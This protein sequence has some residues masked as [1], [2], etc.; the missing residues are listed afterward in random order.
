MRVDQ[1]N[2]QILFVT[3]E[4]FPFSKTGG[5]G[6][7]MG[8]LPVVLKDQGAKVAVITPFYGRLHTADFQIR[9][10]LENCPVGYPW[11]EVTA[12]IYMADYHG[13]PVYFVD[14]PEFFDRKN[15]YC[16]YHGEFFDNC[17][18][19]I[20]FSR[21]AVALARKLGIPPYIMHAHDW[22]SSLVPAYVHA[23]RRLD[24]FWHQTKTVLTIHNLAFQ[25]QYSA[26]LFWSSGL[27]AEAWDMDGAEHY[28]SFNML[29]T[30]IGYAQR[31]TTVSPTYARE[32]VTPEFGCGL[33]G[34]LAKRQP[35]LRGIL[36]GVDYSFWDPKHDK[37]LMY[38]YSPENMQG[39]AECKKTLLYLMGFH[40][41]FMSRPVLGFIGRLREQKGIDIVLEIVDE[42]MAMDVG[43]IIL[44][45]GDLG[46]ETMLG[47]LVE[48]YPGQLAACIGYT[49]EKSHQIMAGTDI[50]LMPSRYEPCGL[51]QLYSLRYGTLPVA[52]QV[53]GL[54]DTVIGYP[55]QGCTGFTFSPITG[56]ALLRA[57]Q[58]AVAVW[59]DDGQ[60][61]RMQERAMHQDFSW[62]RSAREY[63][64]VYREIGLPAEAG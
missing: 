27:P 44:G 48:Q 26:R 40:P 35:D 53:G 22:H 8:V 57:L 31:I 54:L 2:V 21:A 25:G 15:Y 38:P 60:W 30:G 33:H 32:I 13:L 16:T 45:E 18:R 64:S 4:I 63:M 29:K 49:E 9:L 43:L 52:S 11:P 6:D 19:Y 28:G 55:A 24:P 20:F 10:V 50:F 59:K 58:Q 14:R 46:I 17:E 3:S 7:V 42:L 34:I 61:R 62:Q 41:R 37:F 39:K 5:L 23:A 1:E 12:D 36:N 56:P 51:T 47:N